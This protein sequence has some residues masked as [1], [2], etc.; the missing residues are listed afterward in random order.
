MAC[1]SVSIPANISMSSINRPSR[2]VP[3]N[4]TYLSCMDLSVLNGIIA[5]VKLSCIDLE[6]IGFLWTRWFAKENDSECYSMRITWVEYPQQF[7]VHTP[8]DAPWIEL[9][10]CN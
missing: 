10:D 5:D 9:T 3:K 7:S 4:V 8:E 1:L 6:V 2:T